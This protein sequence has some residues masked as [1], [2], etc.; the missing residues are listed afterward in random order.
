MTFQRFPINY[1][2]LRIKLNLKTR[3]EDNQDNSKQII[4]KRL[5]GK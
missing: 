3:I 4:L 1:F 5:N 2:E